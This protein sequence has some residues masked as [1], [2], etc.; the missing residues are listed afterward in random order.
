MRPINVIDVSNINFQYMLEQI[1]LLSGMMMLFMGSLGLLLIIFP[2]FTKDKILQFEMY[3]V[4]AYMIV[5][6]AIL[7]LYHKK[8]IVKG[9]RT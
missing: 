2:N 7:V 4:N 1:L 6:G 3:F 8:I 9:Y 5:L